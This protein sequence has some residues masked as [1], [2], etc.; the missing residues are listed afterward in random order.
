MMYKLKKVQ[1]QIGTFLQGMEGT[2]KA[3][4]STRNQLGRSE[5]QS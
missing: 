5:V 2:R 1:L 4:Q 3:V